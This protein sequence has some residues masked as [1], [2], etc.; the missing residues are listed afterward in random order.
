[1]RL[2]PEQATAPTIG[3]SLADA[4]SRLRSAGVPEPEADA[5]VLLAHA[6][7]TSRAGVVATARDPLSSAAAARLASLLQRRAAREPV[8]YIV[9]EREFWSLP[10]AVDRRVLVPRPETE[11][12]VETALRRSPLARR[13]L[14]CGTGSGAVAAALA[15][16]LPSAT[17]WASDRSRAA[18]G[19][20]RENC[21]RHAPDVRLFAGDLL[22]G[23][24]AAAFDLVVSNPPYVSEAELAAVAPEVREFEPCE[25]L[26]AGPDGLG[27]LRRLISDA[28]RVLAPGG[29]LVV[30]IGA[31]QGAA[32]RRLFEATGCY[33]DL[34]IEDD[35]A[36]IP[37]VVGARRRRDGGWTAS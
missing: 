1:V 33:S 30:E 5:Q 18:L 6:L 27:V 22:T 3:A 11:L 28:T 2:A 10:L 21:A 14:D 23:V 7:G 35:H 12:L 29:W 13:V 31:G 26:A 16:E 4:V 20:A 25:A 37:R 19:V 15:R 17:V 8:A 9:G 36:G 24:R 32:V 34:M